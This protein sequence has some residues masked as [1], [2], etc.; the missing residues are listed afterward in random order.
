MVHLIVGLLSEIYYILA[1]FRRDNEALLAP[2]ILSFFK[3]FIKTLIR[4]IKPFSVFYTFLL[5]FGYLFQ[6][7][8]ELAMNFADFFGIK[9]L[10]I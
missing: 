10:T 1:I 2:S 8:N 9:C 4:Y 3:S 6:F 7:E 5:T